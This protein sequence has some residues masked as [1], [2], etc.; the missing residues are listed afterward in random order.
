MT[1]SSGSEHEQSW[2]DEPVAHGRIFAV[3]DNPISRALE[4]LAGTVGRRLTL[5]AEVTA[6]EDLSYAQL[7]P[8]DAVVIC[9]H[10]IPDVDAI[11]ALVLGGPCGYLAVLSSRSRATATRAELATRYDPAALDRLH[12][13]AGLD[14]GGKAPGEIALSVLAE[15]VAHGYGRPGGSLRA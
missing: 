8:E 5:V 13:P 2:S 15:I 11:V 12:T 3:S 9:D 7:R 1:E 4:R 6:G 14:L 10:D